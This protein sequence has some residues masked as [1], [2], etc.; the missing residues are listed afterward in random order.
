MA[1]IDTELPGLKS[2]VYDKKFYNLA[3]QTAQDGNEDKKFIWEYNIK[4]NRKVRYDNGSST[5]SSPTYRLIVT[6]YDSQSVA[7]TDNV[8]RF[9]YF[10]RTH[11]TDA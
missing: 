10:R 2:V 1:P 11:F 4:V 3:Y 8:A 6:C 7:I 5:C 9:T